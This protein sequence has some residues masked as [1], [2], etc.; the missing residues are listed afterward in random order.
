MCTVQITKNKTRDKMPTETPFK[1]YNV[2]QLF[3]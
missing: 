2:K 1:R 3:K